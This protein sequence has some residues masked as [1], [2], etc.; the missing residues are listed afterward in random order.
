[1]RKSGGETVFDLHTH[2]DRCGHAVGLLENYIESAI[3]KGIRILGLSDHS[4]YFFARDDHPFPGLAMARS[5]FAKYVEEAGALKKKYGD[6]IELLI[7]VESDIYKEHIDLYGRIYDGFPLDYIIGSIH[8]TSP[9]SIMGALDWSVAS[10]EERE[11]EFKRYIE[12]FQLSVQSKWVNII[13]HLDRVN[14][15]YASFQRLLAPYM[16]P[17]LRMMAERGVAM[18]VNTSGYRNT[19]QEWYPSA[20]VI[21]RAHYYGVDITF[22]SDA[23]HPNRVGDGWEKVRETLR[24]IGYKQWVIF[25]QR[26]PCYIEL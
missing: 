13:G 20:D 18:E 10:D 24:Q 7:G 19:T 11:S 3:A 5:E 8:F 26:K 12:L 21:E 25:R 6:R 16:D 9:N 22:G 4:P 1:M 15:G 2:H 17:T 23:H 14:R